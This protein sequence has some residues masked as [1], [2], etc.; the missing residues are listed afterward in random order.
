TK[1]E[2]KIEA[3]TQAL[4]QKNGELNDTL[5]SLRQAQKQLV[6]SE[7]LASLGQLVAGV[8][9]EIN[10]PVGVGVTGAS[11]LAEETAKLQTMYQAG[12]MKRSDLESYV[13]TAATISKLLLS[14]M[15]RAATLIQS[16]KEVAIDQ[17]SQERRRVELK[18]YIEE[19]LLN[20]S[21]MLRKTMHTVTVDCPDA[22][23]VDTYPGA[24]S[25]VLTNFVMNALLHAFADG[26]HGKMAIVV[27]APD[28]SSV[29]LRF[30]DNG[31]GIPQE[32][33]PKIFDP[34][35]TTMR[36]RGGSG[37]GLNIVHNLVTGTLQG[38]VTVDSTLTV[39]TTFILNFPRNAVNG[40]AA[41]IVQG[42]QHHA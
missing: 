4:R 2:Q 16:F 8:A 3:R 11:T 5:D 23:D 34:F 15:E 24:I 21:P 38:K 36:G 6:E 25:Q 20:L 29:E 32:A 12:T 27:R 41:A 28:A 1:L 22:L 7:K 17:T 31:K 10:T 26:D 39:G 33:I 37:L 9:H 40:A 19:V 14:N 13:S 42:R 18:T 35:F 30:S